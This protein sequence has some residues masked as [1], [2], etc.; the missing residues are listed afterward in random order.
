MLTPS[1]PVEFT[2]LFV[3]LSG[4]VK[5]V[6][7]LSSVL[8]SCVR[9]EPG[10][11]PLVRAPAGRQPHRGQEVAGRRAGRHQS[12]RGVGAAAVGARNRHQRLEAAVFLRGEGGGGGR[13]G[14]PPFSQVS[15]LVAYMAIHCRI[16]YR[17]VYCAVLTNIFSG[18]QPI[19]EAVRVGELFSVPEVVGGLHLDLIPVGSLPAPVDL[20]TGS[21]LPDPFRAAQ[22][23]LEVPRRGDDQ[24]EVAAPLLHR[25]ALNVGQPYLTVAVQSSAV[26]SAVYQYYHT[27][28]TKVPMSEIRELPRLKIWR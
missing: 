25:H 22:Q 16:L 7:F 12:V 23:K 24:R 1:Y 26:H 9:S 3:L 28:L 17:I 6:S 19:L 18:Q 4:D 2:I 11:G 15:V 20:E 5:L 10:G 14:G 8:F 13:S 27:L 21:P